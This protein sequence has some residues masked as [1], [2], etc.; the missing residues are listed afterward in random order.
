M[1]KYLLRRILHGLISIIIVVLIVMVMIYS[2]LDKIQIFAQAPMYTKVS[3]NQQVAYRYRRWQEYGYINYV[4]YADYLLSLQQSGEIDEET[5]AAA[6]SFGRKPEN[7]SEIVT[8]YA[9]KES[10]SK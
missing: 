8:E 5:R 6:V 7:D 4:T 3:N 9:Q 10:R 2:M 1:T